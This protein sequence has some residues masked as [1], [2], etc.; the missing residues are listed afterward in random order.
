LGASGW[1][2]VVA[3]QCDVRAAFSE[4]QQ[5]VLAD[6]DYYHGG[7]DFSS[8]DDLMVARDDEDFWE[9]G[10]HSI[11]D[12]MKVIESHEKDEVAAVR[13]L[14]EDEVLAQFGTAQPTAADLE[15]LLATEWNTNRWEGRVTV[16][17][18]DGQP[19]GLG[20][21]GISGD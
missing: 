15:R 12:M 13:V 10:T 17:Y 20:F 21:W 4:V 2:H 1:H 16:L 14:R 8:F 6:G 18:S 9:V 7:Y 11:L 3:H 19:T 5:Q